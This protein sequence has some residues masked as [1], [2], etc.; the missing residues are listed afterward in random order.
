MEIT[1]FLLLIVGLVFLSILLG[2]LLSFP[3]MYLWNTCLIPA[4]PGLQPIGW[5]QAWGISILCTA[6]FK[7]I[8]YGE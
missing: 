2:L 3:V 6:L 7:D 1:E 4:A 8:R 5:L